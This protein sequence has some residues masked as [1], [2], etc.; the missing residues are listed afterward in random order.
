MTL[1]DS[2]PNGETQLVPDPAF[3]LA[4]VCIELPIRRTAPT[5]SPVTAAA[6]SAWRRV[7]P[8]RG[9]VPAETALSVPAARLMRQIQTAPGTHGISRM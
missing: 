9:W 4:T 5:P 7:I 8:R 2:A 6:A 1:A 3:G